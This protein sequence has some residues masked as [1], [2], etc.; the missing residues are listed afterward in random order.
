MAKYVLDNEFNYDFSLLAIASSEPDYKLSIHLNRV[1]GID[2]VRGEPLDLSSKS[3]ASPLVF[4]CFF[5]ED[6]ET[7]D[8]YI[9]FTNLS[10]NSVAAAGAA[11]AGPSLFDETSA[12]DVKGYLVP[13][14][15]QYDYLLLLKGDNHRELARNIQPALK[16]INFLRTYQYVNPE[17]LSSKKNLII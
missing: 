12:S 6:E 9:L 3:T 4:S 7:L 13:E 17:I 1:L 10:Y 5:Y 11:G 14:L 8:Q 16:E 15:S 2:L